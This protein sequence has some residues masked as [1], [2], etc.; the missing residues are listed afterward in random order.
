MDQV[1]NVL[2]NH[3]NINLGSLQT[4]KKIMSLRQKFRQWQAF[5]YRHILRIVEKLDRT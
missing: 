3:K 5:E 2:P 4:V 1:L